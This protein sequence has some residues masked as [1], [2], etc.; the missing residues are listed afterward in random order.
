MSCA[1][2]R[3]R[4]P[5]L[6]T[7]PST[8]P[9]TFNSRAISW[10]AQRLVEATIDADRVP[11]FLIHDRDSIYGGEFR[12][13]VRGLG[14]RRLTIPPRAPQANS[15]CERMIGTL[16]RDCLDHVIIRN[17]RHAERVLRDY[18]DY[19]LGRPHRGL[20][21][22]PPDGARHLPPPRPPP[23]TRIRAAPILGGLDHRYGFE[24]APTV[25]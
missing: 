17:A 13:R 15:F 22:Q 11:R 10:T 8:T 5:A 20:R 25:S 12:A 7:D 6:R 2:I 21:M 1:V 14:A 19:H 4:S 24:A 16:R 3:T 18:A 23:G 9:S